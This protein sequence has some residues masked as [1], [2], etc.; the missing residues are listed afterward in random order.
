MGEH[1]QRKRPKN[2]YRT[3]EWCA[4][5]ARVIETDG[6]ACTVCK[7]RPPEVILQ[8]HHQGYDE[9]KKPW[10]YPIERCHTLCRGCHAREHGLI[11]PREGWD[12]LG[13]EDLGGL[14]GN[15]E[16]CGTEIRYVHLIDHPRWHPMEVGCE[17]CDKLTN[18]DEASLEQRKRT[19]LRDRRRRFMRSPRWKVKDGIHSITID[20][21]R[22]SSAKMISDGLAQSTAKA[23]TNTLP[24]PTSSRSACSIGS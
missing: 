13:E 24:T 3:S 8:V 5:R 14:D 18:T 20:G 4:F 16:L 11:R 6:G 22:S 12:Y 15:C 17:C 7:R 10:E 21:L 9:G 19:R 2:L 1:P 23:G